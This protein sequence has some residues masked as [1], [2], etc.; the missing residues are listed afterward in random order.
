MSEAGIDWP[1]LMRAG[2]QG[3][4]LRPDAFWRLTP[5]ELLIMLG[6]M[7]GVAP[8]GRAQLEALAARFPDVKH[9]EIDDGGTG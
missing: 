4:G 6:E 7:P 3:L 8:M 1:A 2:L 5:A 9:E